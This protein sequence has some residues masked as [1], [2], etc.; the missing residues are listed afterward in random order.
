MPS[1]S[2]YFMFVTEGS[3]AP[4]F[5]YPHSVGQAV[6]GGH[7]YRGCLNPNLE[8]QYIYGDFMNGWADDRFQS[9]LKVH[10]TCIRSLH[11]DRLI[12]T[13]THTLSVTGWT[14]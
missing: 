14:L 13:R 6:I 11:S 2:K 7:V 12:E 1:D 9:D 5:S 8:G 3:V 4:I 10:L